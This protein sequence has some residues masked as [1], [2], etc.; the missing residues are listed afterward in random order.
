M[1]QWGD[2]RRDKVP[3]DQEAAAAAGRRALAH[4]L[5][6]AE[7]RQ[8][9]GVTQV[10]LAERLGRR[11]GTIS[12]LE[13]RDDVFVSSLREYIE[14]LGGRLEIAAVFDEDRVPLAIADR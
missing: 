14:A 3:A 2:I 1:R 13:R 5:V 10:E 12:E 9:R 6:L 8:Q 7:L 4:A 11:Q